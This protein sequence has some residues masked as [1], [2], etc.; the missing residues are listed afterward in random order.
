MR[1]LALVGGE[2]GADAVSGDPRFAGSVVLAVVGDPIEWLELAAAF[3][4]RGDR[5][6]GE[7]V[8]SRRARRVGAESRLLPLAMMVAA[9]TPP[10]MVVARESIVALPDDRSGRRSAAL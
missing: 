7:M 3:D 2:P 1:A 9:R 5:S 6:S 8:K 4:R 10:G